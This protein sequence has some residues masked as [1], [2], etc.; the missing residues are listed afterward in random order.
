MAV[1]TAKRPQLGIMYLLMV[2]TRN[3]KYY[4]QKIFKKSKSDSD[5]AYRSNWQRTGNTGDRRGC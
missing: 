4:C 1:N 2:Y 5:Q 3:I